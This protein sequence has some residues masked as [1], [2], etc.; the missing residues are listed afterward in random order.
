MSITA[1]MNEYH[2]NRT[3][4]DKIKN[5]NKCKQI[6]DSFWKC[7]LKTKSNSNCSQYHYSFKKCMEM[8]KI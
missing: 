3:S 8:Y 6:S 1:S 7:V 2:K 5:I 4:L